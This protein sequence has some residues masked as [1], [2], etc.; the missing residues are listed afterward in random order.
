MSAE[1][2]AEIKA[3]IEAQG[4]AWDKF[5]QANDAKLT[6]FDK[7]LSELWLRA[8]RPGAN[9]FNTNATGEVKHLLTADGHK[10]PWLTKNQ[11]FSDACSD[12]DT[13]DFSLG[14]F[15]KDAIVG[16]RKAQSGPALVPLLIGSQI[17]DAVRARTVLVQAGAGSI[18]IDGP[19]N[20]AR[21]TT[22]P[23][24]YVHTE[25]AVDISESDVV[26]EPVTLNPKVLAVLVPLTVEL[27]A[28]SPNL[29]ALLSIALAGAFAAKVDTLGLALL[30]ADSAIP[31][32]AAG[33]DPA[34]WAKVLEAV[35]SALALNQAVPTAHVSA[36]SDFIA[37]ASQL[38]STAGSWLG[39]PPALS[40]MAEFQ[41]T[42]LS[43]GTAL[44]G[45]FAAAFALAVRSDLRVEVVRHAKPT[46][47]SHLL[48]AHMRVGPV[49]LQPGR[50]FRQLKTVI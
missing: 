35:G 45:D 38:A 18:M 12:R 19:T 5:K 49:V 25:A 32:S 8:G 21:L 9:V 6:Q 24:V 36:P 1:N 26:A 34:V 17:I 40:G 48:V 41:T 37:R 43:A 42:S 23:T 11:Q 47:G 31:E 46:S 29:D 20:L 13:G 7:G 4:G 28:D 44:F 33:Q 22:D 30:L 3:L 15:C 2:I 10:L 14:Q 39:K 27:V 16:S 50:L